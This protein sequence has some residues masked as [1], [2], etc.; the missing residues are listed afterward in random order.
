MSEK[1]RTRGKSVDTLLMEALEDLNNYEHAEKV[2]DA[3]IQSARTRVITL[4]Q[5]VAQKQKKQT[6]D[7]FSTLQQA[8]KTLVEEVTVLRG[9]VETLK[10]RLAE[11]V[12]P[13]AAPQVDPAVTTLMADSTFSSPNNPTGSPTLERMRRGEKVGGGPPK[14]PA[15]SGIPEHVFQP[16]RLTP[17][18][19]EPRVETLAQ[20]RPVIPPPE[21]E[22]KA[23]AKSCSQFNDERIQANV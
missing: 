1:K 13:V 4:K 23:I 20:S 6:V 14:L 22:K 16:V 17:P 12:T 5:R 18:R 7:K 8:V 19:V 21:T 10:Q 3:R 9:E 11:P 15:I 2:D